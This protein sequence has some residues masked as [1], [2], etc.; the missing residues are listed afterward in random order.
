M[1]KIM[2]GVFLSLLVLAL[3]G[4]AMALWPG[5]HRVHFFQKPI[6]SKVYEEARRRAEEGG[7]DAASLF[8]ARI[9][10]VGYSTTTE[11]TVEEVTMKITQVFDGEIPKKEF[12]VKR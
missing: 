3:M 11:K 6:P 8:M 12:F 7:A 1:L 4:D 5:A 2:R 10:I 9:Q